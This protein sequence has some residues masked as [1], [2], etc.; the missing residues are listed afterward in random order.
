MIKELIKENAKQQEQIGELI[1][2]IG[3]NNTNIYFF[4]YFQVFFF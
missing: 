3:N 4:F 1:P 2:K